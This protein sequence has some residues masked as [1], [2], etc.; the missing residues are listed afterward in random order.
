MPILA[1][2]VDAVMKLRYMMTSLMLV[3]AMVYNQG[4]AF[5]QQS[6]VAGSAPQVF[7]MPVVARMPEGLIMHGTAVVGNRIYI[8]GGRDLGGARND[9]ISAPIISPAQIGA[10]RPEIPLPERRMYIMSSVEVVDNRIYVVGGAIAANYETPDHLTTVANDALFAELGPDGVLGQWKRSAKFPKQGLSLS[11]TCSSQRFLYVTGGQEPGSGVST[12]IL[13]ARFDQTGT[14]VDWQLAGQLP[15]PRWFHGAAIMDNRM[16]VWG[17]AIKRGRVGTDNSEV[18]SVHSADVDINGNLGPWKTQE[19]MPLPIYS[20]AFCGFNDMLVCSAG[21]TSNRSPIGEIH[22]A[23]TRT[24]GTL[25]PWRRIPTDL[26]ARVYHAA[27]LDRLQGA[28]YITGGRYVS[29]QGANGKPL[30]L[31]Q[32][33]VI[34]QQKGSKTTLFPTYEDAVKKA[35]TS[36]KQILI[37]FRSPSVPSCLRMEEEIQK[38]T[39]MLRHLGSKYEL[40]MVDMLQQGELG[41]KFGIFRVPTV[42]ICDPAGSKILSKSS[43]LSDLQ[44]LKD[45]IE[46]KR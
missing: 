22:F 44:D 32:A 15:T 9:V 24:D 20:S 13:R 41:Y 21:R 28:V 38:D 18:A 16:Y 37:Y 46:G 34:P 19:N 17:G 40:A 45:Y 25:E 42:A 29:P 1:R 35:A 5:A 36:R 30:D 27:G 3:V 33:F 8:I 4:A 12:Q 43:W 2:M 23:R 31:I 14:P 7:S 10:W 11:A 39:E 6:Q 26:S